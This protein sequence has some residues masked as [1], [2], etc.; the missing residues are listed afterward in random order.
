MSAVDHI[1]CPTC[2]RFTYSPIH[3]LTRAIGLCPG[4]E[5]P[6]PIC[7][8]CA[9]QLTGKLRRFRKR[10]RECAPYYRETGQFLTS[11][12]PFRHLSRS[13]QIEDK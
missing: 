12:P 8:W 10:C 13:G 11:P 5:R 1:M 2:L 6:P 4:P 3:L 7:E 9:I